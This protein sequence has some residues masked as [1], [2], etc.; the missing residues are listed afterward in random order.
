ME[1]KPNRAN[2]AWFARQRIIPILLAAL[3]ASILIGFQYTSTVNAVVSPTNTTN[4]NKYSAVGLCTHMIFTDGTTYYAKNCTTGAITASGTNAATVIQTTIAPKAN[5]LVTKGTYIIDRTI[6]VTSS[7]VKIQ[8]DGPTT[9]VFD[10]NPGVTVFQVGTNAVNVITNTFRDLSIVTGAIGIKKLGAYNLYIEDVRIE[11][12]TETG[13]LLSGNGSNV[14]SNGYISNSLFLTNRDGIETRNSFAALTI[15]N[16]YVDDNARY[17]IYWNSGGNNLKVIGGEVANNHGSGIYLPSGHTVRNFHIDGVNFDGISGSAFG[18][19]T[20]ISING[21]LLGFAVIGSYFR[22]MTAGGET[23]YVAGT[24][25]GI[26]AGNV[27]LGEVVFGGQEQDVWMNGNRYD[28]GTGGASGV[29]GYGSKNFIADTNSIVISPPTHPIFYDEFFGDSVDAKWRSTG[30]GTPTFAM[31]NQ[32]N[33]VVRMTTSAASS[34]TAQLDFGQLKVI[35]ADTKP[36]FTAQ[37]KT[38]SNSSS[39][40]ISLTFD[41]NNKIWLGK[42]SNT[43]ARIIVS[44]NGVHTVGTFTITTP[45]TT[46]QQWQFEVRDGVVAAYENGVAKSTITATLPT[47]GL[48]PTIVITT[49]ETSAHYMDLDYVDIRAQRS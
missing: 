12:M 43:Q 7:N 31:Q 44:D 5:I 17:G 26:I 35:S 19:P 24:T 1:E 21:T 36:L 46:M 41:N 25:N 37:L 32:T 18:H 39:W 11:E 20:G 10:G 2:S 45:H 33:G 3:T 47:E 6:N 28:T 13:L 16:S 38:D 48:E 8:G 4:Y 14:T 49:S 29:R 40:A 15:V 30:T 42:F 27:F 34:D 23:M 22:V 9:T